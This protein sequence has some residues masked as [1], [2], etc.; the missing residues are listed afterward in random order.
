MTTAGIYIQCPHCGIDIEI[1]E[2]NC[3]IFICGVDKNGK[4]IDPHLPKE[5]CEKLNDIYGCKNSFKYMN[6]KLE[7]M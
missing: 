1:V 5:Q 6:G 7:K 4:Q 3:G 2:I